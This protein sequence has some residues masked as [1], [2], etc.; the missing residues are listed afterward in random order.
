[1]KTHV[2]GFQ[3]FFSPFFLHHFVTAKLATSSIRVKVM[4]L[5]AHITLALLVAIFTIQNDAKKSWKMTKNPDV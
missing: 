2:S 4:S 3:V 1:M 5:T